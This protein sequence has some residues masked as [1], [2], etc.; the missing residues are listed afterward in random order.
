M[1]VR[2]IPI[3]RKT[4]IALAVVFAG[5][6]FANDAGAQGFGEAFQGFSADSEDPIQIERPEPIPQPLAD[7]WIELLLHAEVSHAKGVEQSAEAQ[8]TG[9]A[10]Q[11]AAAQELHPYVFTERHRA[12]APDEPNA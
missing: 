12:T 7:L 3:R 10:G 11:H 9:L 5:A 6:L 1:N 8:R 4:S 2:E